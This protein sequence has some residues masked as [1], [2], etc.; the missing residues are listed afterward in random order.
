VW[1]PPGA[2]VGYVPKKPKLFLSGDWKS[3]A[4]MLGINNSTSTYPC[5]YCYVS[6]LLKGIFDLPLPPGDADRCVGEHGAPLSEWPIQRSMSSAADLQ[7]QRLL[8]RFGQKLLPLLEFIP[9]SHVIMDELH[10]FLRIA[11]LLI[12]LLIYEVRCRA[13]N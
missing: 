13:M 5:I 12:S 10:V 11:D 7:K 2:P 1:T 3:L 4:M 9:F 6:K 8:T